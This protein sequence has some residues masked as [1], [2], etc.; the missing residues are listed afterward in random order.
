MTAFV[1]R[2]VCRH[3]RENWAGDPSFA[4]ENTG[5]NE[6]DSHGTVG[7]TLAGGNTTLEKTGSVGITSQEKVV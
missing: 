4:E 5:L 7:T 2:I 1:C 6:V 3:L